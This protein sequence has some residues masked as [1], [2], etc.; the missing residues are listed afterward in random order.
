MPKIINV[1]SKGEGGALILR[2]LTL[3]L[4]CVQEKVIGTQIESHALRP[5]LSKKLMYVLL[6]KPQHHITKS[7]LRMLVEMGVASCSGK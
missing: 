2:G 4:F 3:C 6:L 1:Y 7:Q 5:E